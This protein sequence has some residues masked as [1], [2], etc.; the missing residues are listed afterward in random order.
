MGTMQKSFKDHLTESVSASEFGKASNLIAKYLAKKLKLKLF[1][2]PSVEKYMGKKG[3]RFGIRFYIPKG[4]KSLRFNWKNAGSVSSMN[5]DSIDYWDGKNKTPLN[6]QFD[7]QV[8]LVRALPAFANFINTGAKSKTL[9]VEPEAVPIR[10]NLDASLPVQVLDY[11]KK[12]PEHSATDIGNKFTNAGYRIHRELRNRYPGAFSKSGRKFVWSGG[13]DLDKDIKGSSADILSSIGAVRGSLSRGSSKEVYEV[14]PEVQAVEANAD[15]LVFE[16]QLEDYANLLK[17]M[18]S[19]ASNALFVAGRG[20][21]GKT[22]TA[23]KELDALGLVDNRDYFKNTGS[24]SAAGLYRLLFKYRNRIVFFDDSDNVFADQESRNI[25]KAA[26]DTKKIRKLV[27]SKRGSDVVDPEEYTDEEME[28]Q[29]LVPRYF[30]FTGKIIFISNLKP[31]K[32]DPDGALR[33]RAF[34]VNIDPT[35]EEIYDFMEKIVDKMPLDDGMELDSKDRKYVVTLLRQ[36]KSSQSANLRKLSR[37]LN[38]YAG[39]LKAG[40]NVSK[41]EMER[42]ISMYA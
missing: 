30:E 39:S 22:F 5:L 38:M 37:G 4:A 15:R 9:Y 26:T 17:M 10:E 8:S 1:A 7:D 32:L 11:M 40:V 16:K 25:L 19:G 23:E 27:Y 28:D 24:I 18:Y 20:G 13:N 6:I 14:D 31:D 21:I 33:T 35:E 12:N 42:M 34:M 41:A 36:G 3:Q 29:N 2:H